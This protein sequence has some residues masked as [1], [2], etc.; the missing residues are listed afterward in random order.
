MTI[1]FDV[2]DLFQY[3]RTASRLGGIQRC[4]YELYAA[5]V[6]LAPQQVGFLRHGT[7]GHGMRVIAWSEVT[8]VYEAL[9]HDPRRVEARQYFDH[10]KP[11]PVLQ[12]GIAH[13]PV[14][15]RLLRAFARRVPFEVRVPLG[16]AMRA[17]MTVF[18]ALAAAVRAIPTVWAVSHRRRPEADAASPASYGP[19]GKDLS[20]VAA[21]G[22]FLVALGAPWAY[23][24]YAGRIIRLAAKIGIRF[25]IL[26]HD[27]IPI[28]RPEF[29]QGGDDLMFASFMRDCVSL[30]D[31]LM[32]VSEATANDV[33][34]FM[35]NANIDIL[36]R[37]SVLRIGTGFTLPEGKA[38]LPDN[39]V[40][41]GYALFVSTIEP[42]KNHILAFL[43][44]RRLLETLPRDQVPQ[45]VFAGRLGW[46]VSDLMQ[47]I[48]NSN[49]LGGKLTIVEKPDDGLLAALYRGARFTLFPS[50]HEG[51]GLPVSESLAFGKVCLASDSSSIPEAG[52]PFCLYHDPENVTAAFD[53]YRRA[54]EDPNLIPSM[55]Q[56]IGEA[57]R[58][59][60][61][62][63][64]AR[65]MMSVLL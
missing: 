16:Q 19:V 55:E 37:P 12:S 27:I 57:Y 43:A 64:S 54:I 9:A 10:D 41:G 35:R 3:A 49:Y 14:I 36:T 48:R 11:V 42:R 47:R 8:R 38:E 53:L 61:W 25:A 24:D 63:T 21:P 26:I 30:A 45:L 39:L 7:N 32:A 50:F 31:K 18:R 59:V 5:M 51:W 52:G 40:A 2:E 44:W 65:D 33:E 1:W 20:D 56:R 23:L 58:P 34:S 13:A 46:M 4:S 28:L 29:F 15:G 62:S 60:P 17:Q 6:S 22:D